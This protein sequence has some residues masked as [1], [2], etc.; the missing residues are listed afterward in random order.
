MKKVIA[1]ISFAVLLSACQSQEIIPTIP[2]TPPET[3][4]LAPSQ[5][6]SPEPTFT[7]TPAPVV[8]PLEVG[9][10]IPTD[11]SSL[12]ITS[13]TASTLKEIVR[14]KQDDVVIFDAKYWD[15][16]WLVDTNQ[17]VKLL[18]ESGEWLADL[19]ESQRLCPKSRN[20]ITGNPSNIYVGPG[21]IG[22][23][24]LDGAHVYS[25]DGQK[26]IAF[27]PFDEQY[28]FSWGCQFSSFISVVSPDMKWV[29]VTKP[30]ISYGTT[31]IFSIE[32]G[33]HVISLPGDKVHMFSS[34]SQYLL[35]E[36]G[37]NRFFLYKTSDWSQAMLI[38]TG[39]FVFDFGFSPSGEYLVY[40]RSM[41]AV[42][43]RPPDGNKT[44]VIKQAQSLLF[45][46][47]TNEIGALYWTDTD[48][49]N[50]HVWDFDSG[51]E[52]RVDKVGT[53]GWLPSTID[54]PSIQGFE[55][56]NYTDRGTYNISCDFTGDALSC[57]IGPNICT[58]D[59]TG[60]MD[61]APVKTQ[62]SIKKTIGNFE[63]LL[64]EK[65]GSYSGILPPWE[66]AADKGGSSPTWAMTLAENNPPGFF[67]S[68][69]SPDKKHFVYSTAEKF[70]DQDI[71]LHF[72]A[73]E[74][75]VAQLKIQGLINAVISPDSKYMLAA[76]DTIGN[77]VLL[78]D[79]ET[80]KVVHEF[81]KINDSGRGARGLAFSSDSRLAAYLDVKP[82]YESG[83]PLSMGK[84]AIYDLIESKE[85]ISIDLDL[86]KG[87]VNALAF[88]PD[89]SLIAV[90][91][92]DGKV[93]IYD[94][95]SGELINSWYAHVG[96][97]SDLA[98]STDGKWLM[99]AGGMD[100]TIR[101]WA[102]TQE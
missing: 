68:M 94:R 91:T 69:M 98:F 80:G 54:R 31:K 62:T 35:L 95:V 81:V 61:C 79:L 56:E 52:I 22:V 85:L 28:L 83:T 75:E 26:Q 40:Q 4:T 20:M 77:Q 7:P 96:V 74:N 19:G 37:E 70:F 15:G 72:V 18:K 45:N 38:R 33:E 88:S 60:G 13:E 41:G 87:N 64:Y 3:M 14:I 71:T 53:D 101:L 57:F 82:T 5:T 21:G 100:E 42:V 89:S 97:V 93:S 55:L 24:G 9:T 29:A 43:L 63:Y 49:E 30:G 1:L 36:S 47:I 6:P 78:W 32:S 17:G 10:A 48:Q 51:E 58:Y 8:F 46:K 27:V 44:L 25:L 66:M 16:T 65:D 2:T 90:G 67:W 76:V 84:L 39:E 59:L 102:V 50:I 92:F 86:K 11:F 73:N 12:N 99:T 34:D 23:V